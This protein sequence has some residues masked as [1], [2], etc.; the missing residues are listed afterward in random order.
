MV[1][2]TTGFSSY[3]DWQKSE[4]TVLSNYSNSFLNDSF[5]LLESFYNI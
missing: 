3:F 5:P 1:F 4:S 2:Y